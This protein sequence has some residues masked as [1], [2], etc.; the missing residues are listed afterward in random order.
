MNLFKGR[1]LLL[2]TLSSWALAL[3]SFSLQAQTLSDG[4]ILGALH[5]AFTM[6]YRYSGQYQKTIERKSKFGCNQDRDFL[7]HWQS[8]IKNLDVRLSE[9]NVAEFKINLVKSKAY[10]SY[11]GN[12]MACMYKGYFGDI[13]SDNIDGEF[14]IVPQPNREPAVIEIKS[15]EVSNL[16]FANWTLFDPFLWD[17]Q[18]S[19]PDFINQ[20]AQNSLNG[21]IKVLL[22]SALTKH[23][24][25]YVSKKVNDALKERYDAEKPAPRSLAS[26][27]LLH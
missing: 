20:W 19:A 10:V 16:Q 24:N 6:H 26:A 23:L 5:E 17:V 8:E 25:K 22:N 13:L 2:R 14:H 11:G 1:L 12:N 18:G 21:T 4:E 9:K 7:L 27:P 3:G 15:L